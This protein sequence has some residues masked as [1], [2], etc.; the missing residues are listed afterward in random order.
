MHKV[1]SRGV[2][3]HRGYR[4]S[5]R[6]R[7]RCA[8]SCIASVSQRSNCHTAQ[9]D[10]NI[11]PSPNIPVIKCK[12]RKQQSCKRLQPVQSLSGAYARSCLSCGTSEYLRACCSRRP[13]MYWRQSS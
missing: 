2:S 9:V 13:S 11:L 4:D 6:V 3:V 7:C 10:L 12:R 5:A 1:F 8:R